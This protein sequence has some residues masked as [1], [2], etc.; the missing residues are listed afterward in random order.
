MDSFDSFDAPTTTE[1][2]ATPLPSSATPAL[3]AAAPA[4]VELTLG[5]QLSLSALWLGINAISAA[6]L[7]IVLPIE[8]LLFIAPGNVGDAQ[9][10]EFL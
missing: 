2:H 6:L 3:V 9:Q 7:P 1:P 10:A 4:L 5:R 8:I